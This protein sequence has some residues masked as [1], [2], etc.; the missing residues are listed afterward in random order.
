[1]K[2][3]YK[4][5]PDGIKEAFDSL[6]AKKREK[7]EK[8]VD[9]NRKDFMVQLQTYINSLE[10]A[11]QERFKE[12]VQRVFKEQDALIDWSK[13]QEESSSSSDSDSDKSDED[14]D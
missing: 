12:K 3:V 7:Y 13:E 14:S 11:D 8:V 9:Q 5:P 6:S 2:H 4:G 10:T 1:M